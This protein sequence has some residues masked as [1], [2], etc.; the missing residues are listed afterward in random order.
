MALYHFWSLPHLW[1]VG[2]GVLTGSLFRLGYGGL[3]STIEAG[4]DGVNIRPLVKL[5]SRRSV[6]RL[7][8]D[9]SDVDISIHGLAYQRIPVVG[10]KLSVGA[11]KALERRWG[12][13]VVS[14]A[15]K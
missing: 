11:G 2:K 5:Y 9:F 10:P 4:A 13:Y 8:S 3:L 6:T 14:R 1:L 15:V 12:W 7:L